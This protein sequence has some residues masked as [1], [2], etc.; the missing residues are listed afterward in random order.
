MTFV[1]DSKRGK[2]I[3]VLVMFLI[4]MVLGRLIWT[5]VF[6]I[7]EKEIKDGVISFK[8]SEELLSKT[9]FLNGDWDYYPEKILSQD[10]LGE[11]E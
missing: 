11:Y 8:T 10:E 7:P 1:R 3:I 9:Y 2:S 4:M 6:F 5:Y